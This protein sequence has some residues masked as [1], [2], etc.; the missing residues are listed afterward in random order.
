MEPQ[1]SEF[2]AKT[3]HRLTAVEESAKSAHHR[4]DEN[5]E[6]TSGIHELATNIKVM[7]NQL[8]GLGKR[9]D[10]SIE[11][12]NAGQRNQGE[13]IGKLENAYTLTAQI[14]PRLETSVNTLTT[15]VDTLEKEPGQKWKTVTAQIIGLVVAAVVGGALMKLAGL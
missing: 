6:L 4:I 3:E 9:S 15:K 12:I 8:E 1:F 5:D 14:M 13:R 11:R 2:I 10:E 7:A